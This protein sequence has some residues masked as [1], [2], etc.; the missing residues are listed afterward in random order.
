MRVEDA[1]LTPNAL[2]RT[3]LALIAAAALAL[4]FLAPGRET[5]TL[6]QPIPTETATPVP[7]AIPSCPSNT[8]DR[9]G[10]GQDNGDCVS[11]TSAVLDNPPVRCSLVSGS[12]EQYGRVICQPRWKLNGVAQDMPVG[13]VLAN[14]GC[15][16]VRRN[17][18]P[19]LMVGLGAPTLSYNG[20]LATGVASINPGNWMTG[21]SE[22]WYQT[23]FSPSGRIGLPIDGGFA[24]GN[25]LGQAFGGSYT[26]PEYPPVRLDLS[27]IDIYPSINNVSLRLVYVQMPDDRIDVSI[28]GSPAPFTPV[29][30]DRS[31][32]LH[33]LVNRSSNP[34]A[35]IGADDLVSSGGADL[36]GQSTLP[37]YRIQIESRWTLYVQWRF[38]LW[39]IRNNAY[40][41]AMGGGGGGP[42]PII[43]GGPVWTWPV[44]TGTRA[45][46]SQQRSSV[47]LIDRPNCNAIAG[48]G[49]IPVPVME[50]HSILIR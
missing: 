38:E 45:W 10:N 15:L 4:V 34:A 1:K 12:A 19:R 40:Q 14:Q 20:V 41:P 50:G 5:P 7:T 17:P 11:I 6:A 2:A 43:A 30:W 49:Y 29:E 23:S 33:F 21:Y 48:D 35:A 47:G 46:D 28:S 36:N 16:D 39:E 25:W 37:A 26:G 3:G 27:A 24:A 32:P 13:P 31:A 9:N 42:A 22:G 44:R 8:I 18:F